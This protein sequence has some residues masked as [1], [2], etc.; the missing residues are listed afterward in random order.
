MA[1]LEELEARLQKL[2]D[3]REIERLQKIYGYYCDYF[4]FNKVVDLFSDNAE[5]V[6]IADHDVRKRMAAFHHL[7]EAILWIKAGK[8]IHIGKA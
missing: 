2:T 6:E 7:G 1:T 8:D 4:E 5:S 3:I